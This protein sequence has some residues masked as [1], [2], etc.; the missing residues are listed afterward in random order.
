M[1][2]DLTLPLP[3]VLALRYLRS[4]RRDAF[5]TFLSTV[6]AG[7]IALG[8]AVLILALAMLSGFQRVLKA[9]VL[10]RTSEIEIALPADA[11]A[12]AVLARAR[13]VAGVREAQLVIRG[14]GWLVEKGQAQAVELV[15][16]E[17]ELPASFPAADGRQPGLYIGSAL[18]RRWSLGPGDGVDVVSPRPTLTPLG[19]QPRLRHFT[20]A[21]RFESSTAGD[22]GDKV[23]LPLAAAET[24]VDRSNRAVIVSAGGLEAALATAPQLQQALP[25]LTIRTWKDLNRPLFFALG[26]EKVLTFVAIGLVLVVA[27]LALIA[28]LALVIANKRPEIGIL[29]ACGAPKGMLQRA[30]L[31]LGTLLAAIGVGLGGAVGTVTAWVL[32]REQLVPIPGQVY[33]VDHVPFWV[34][35]LDVV[36]IVGLSA[37][38]VLASAAYAA[39]RATLLSPIEAMRR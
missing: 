15:G 8:V 30:F 12:P 36:A 3:W 18:A 7:G 5:V 33:F 13:A 25:G 39:R 11:D 22:D 4:T 23:A 35:P 31:Y 9:Q 24:L 19:P 37:V 20:I 26:L 1:L 16:Y 14:R 28:D 38:L 34:R 32:D 29:E 21:G 2:R 17:G 6:A 10:A 27:S